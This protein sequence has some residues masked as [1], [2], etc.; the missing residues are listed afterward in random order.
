MLTSLLPRALCKKEE[1]GEGRQHWLSEKRVIRQQD[2]QNGRREGLAHHTRIPSRPCSTQYPPTAWPLHPL[3]LSLSDYSSHVR[4]SKTHTITQRSHSALYLATL[5]LSLPRTC[6]SASPNSLKPSSA[7]RASHVRPGPS[8]A[9]GES[10]FLL[11]P[12]GRVF[13]LPQGRAAH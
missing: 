12:A 9:A 6:N 10:C 13:G 1:R 7:P 4:A 8:R 5:V 11:A 2:G 3:Q